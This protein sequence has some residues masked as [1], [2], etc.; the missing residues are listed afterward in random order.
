M[1]SSARPRQGVGNRLVGAHLSTPMVSSTHEEEA[2][3]RAQDPKSAHRI[4]R[5]PTTPTCALT[6]LQ[7]DRYTW[8]H[9]SALERSGGRKAAPLFLLP[10]THDNFAAGRIPCAS[11]CTYTRPDAAPQQRR[12]RRR[13][14]SDDVTLTDGLA[15]RKC[16]RQRWYQQHVCNATEDDATS[17]LGLCYTQPPSIASPSAAAAH[18]G[19]R[20]ARPRS[21]AAAP[22][23]PCLETL[24]DRV[25]CPPCTDAP[26]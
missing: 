20:A 25:F 3:V 21:L 22:E 12:L 7:A 8:A 6:S 26:A 4:S 18:W 5:S 15:T 14:S 1:C 13:L 24:A 9:L 16:V 2:H 23:P 19:A 17:T 11:I 10:V